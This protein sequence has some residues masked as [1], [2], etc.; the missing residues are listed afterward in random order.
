[1][2]AAQ[3]EKDSARKLYYVAKTNSAEN[4]DELNQKWNKKRESYELEFKKFLEIRGNCEA[5]KYVEF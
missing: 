5:F 2:L 1:M 4:E 3:D